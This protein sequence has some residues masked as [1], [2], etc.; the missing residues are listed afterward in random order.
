MA[1]LLNQIIEI[2]GTTA[3]ESP[4]TPQIIGDW[5]RSSQCRNPWFV[6]ESQAQMMGFQWTEPRAKLP[7]EA[8]DIATFVK[9]GATGN[10][11]GAQLFAATKLAVNNLGFFWINAAVRSD[12]AAGLGFYRKM[13]FVD[14]KSDPS[15]ALASGQVTGK[16]YLRFDVC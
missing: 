13:G 1:E 7:P 16:T 14:W 5:M 12:N 10:G 15:V 11:V 8:T 3:H 4:V 9:V 2:G 6:A